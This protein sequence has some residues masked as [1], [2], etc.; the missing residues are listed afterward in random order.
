MSPLRPFCN[1]LSIP[2]L[3]LLALPPCS[4]RASEPLLL[5]RIDLV[6]PVTEL[7]L[8]VH[9]YLQAANGQDYVLVF[10]DR[11]QLDAAG[12]AYRVLDSGGRPRDYVVARYRRPPT[13]N[14]AGGLAVVH[15]DGRRWIVRATAAR[16]ERLAERGFDV[17]RLP[18]KPLAW[19]RLA[20]PEK[21]GPK[22]DLMLLSYDGMVADM[23]NQV[24][25]TNLYNWVN[26]LSGG[27][28]SVIGGDF[29]T[30][31]TRNTTRQVPTHKAAQYMFQHLQALG[32]TTSY[33]HW[34]SGG[35]SNCN[36]IGEMPGGALSNEI[37]IVCAH[38]D[39]MPNAARAPGADDNASGS[40]G[41][42]VAADILRKF[43]F[44]RTLRFVLF[45]GEEQDLYG[46]DAYAALCD[47]RGDN[48]LAVLNLDMIAWDSDASPTLRLHTRS[49]NAG[50]R[51]IAA[52]FTNVVG[53]YSLRSRLTPIITA[54]NET[55][56]DHS[57]FWNYGYYAVLAI[58]DDYDD[59]HTYYH[60]TNDTLP[61]MNMTYFTWYT[62]AVVGT[63]A[64]LA[65]PVEPVS[66]DLIQVDNGDWVSGSGVGVGT[67]YVKHEEGATETGA[68]AH[69]RSSTNA[70]FNPNYHWLGLFTT[71]YGER[72]GTDAR[73]T[74]SDTIFYGTMM[75]V[76]TNAGSFSCATNRLRFTYLASPD[77]NRIYTVRV[78]VQTN[79][80]RNGVGVF[81]VTNLR[82]LVAGSGFLSLPGLT[83]LTNGAV[84]GTCEISSRPIARDPTNYVF[85][86]ASVQ[87]T[88][89]GLSAPAQTGSRLVDV[90]ELNT[91]LAE[92]G[93]TW[94]FL[95]AFTNYV[96]P[97]SNNFEAGWQPLDRAARL[98]FTNAPDVYFR[99]QRQWRPL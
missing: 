58:E 15:D 59:F 42:L 83:N 16:A 2:V 92:G 5:A 77:S 24:R 22:E 43:R 60:T 98:S 49:G 31:L 46:S 68:D 19:P 3:C 63:A 45:T 6:K 44:Q 50:D 10:A 12:W 37:V 35:Y 9:A 84:Y 97:D 81:C 67:L 1:F 54:D 14:A 36:V 91:N 85:S 25:T 82:D 66:F 70:P 48:V 86:L 95:G 13:G 89:I 78:R 11:T 38:L 47:A 99:F 20:V 72:L 64:H 18:A 62:K 7:P 94:L 57:S 41:V 73:P 96:T 71:P 87:G 40:V 80:T 52:T 28:G 53:V 93:G 90:V 17:Q 74:N 56:S 26:Q 79:Y 33:Q 27:A 55:A 32:L 75:A 65:N 51:A 76:K 4:A 29:Y 23:I 61:R 69:D 21:R 8:P 88:N 34:N 30:I 39:D